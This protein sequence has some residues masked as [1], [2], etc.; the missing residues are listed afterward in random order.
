V[1]GEG[2]SGEVVKVSMP[3]FCPHFSFWSV[4]I[5]V[6][7]TSAYS[8]ITASAI[9]FHFKNNMDSALKC[10]R[11]CKSFILTIY[12]VLQGIVRAARKGRTLPRLTLLL[13]IQATLHYGNATTTTESWQ[14]VSLLLL[15]TNIMLNIAG[16]SVLVLLYHHSIRV[17]FN[18]KIPTYKDFDIA[19]PHPAIE[20]FNTHLLMLRP[21]E[22]LFRFLTAPLRVLPDVIVLGEVRCGTTNLCAHMTSLSEHGNKVKCYPPFCPWAHPE[23]DHKESFYFVG[24]YLGIVDPYLYRMAFPLVVSLVNI[25]LLV[26]SILQHN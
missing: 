20:S 16:Y 10:R 19:R 13:P 18:R 4:I 7:E 5:L 11:I 3:S 6:G 23:L 12:E 25:S 9:I 22:I 14:T 15:R 17:I 21:L 26:D 8:S 24:H 2:G 1:E